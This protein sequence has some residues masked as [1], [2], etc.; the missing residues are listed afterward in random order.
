MD[1]WDFVDQA[2]LTWSNLEINFNWRYLVNLV[3]NLADEL[4]WQ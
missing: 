3:Q 2:A 1:Q 4:N